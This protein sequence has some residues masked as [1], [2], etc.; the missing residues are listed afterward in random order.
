MYSSDEYE[1]MK[2][3]KNS[4]SGGFYQNNK[5]LV[6]VFIAIILIAIVVV[7]IKKNGDSTSSKTNVNKYS[8]S[9]YP[10]NDITLS[11]GNSTR[12][13]AIV[14]SNASA[15]VTWSSSDDGVVS[16][17]NGL[18]RA[19]KY[20][21]TVITATYTHTDSKSYTSKKEITVADGKKDVT[22]SDISI[23]DG[24]LAMPLS[25]TYNIIT[26]PIPSD[27]YVFAKTLTS[28]NE[29]VVKINDEGMIQ[30]VSEGEA[31]VTININEGVIIRNLKVYVSNTYTNT[32]MILNPTKI[33]LSKEIDKIKIGGSAQISYV[34]EPNEAKNT[35]VNWTSSNESVLKVDK[36]GIIEGINEGMATIKIEALNGISDTL[37]ILV[38]SELSQATDIQ[39]PND[40]YFETGQSDTIIPIIIPENAI[41]KSVTC[42]SNNP[43]IVT[44]NS[45][46]TSCVITAISEGQAV[47][48]VKVNSTDVTKNINVIVSAPFKQSS[49]GGSSCRSCSKTC[50]SGQYCS[51]G[52][53]VS[54]KSGNYCS[55]G[56]KIACPAGK[57]S[58]SNSTMPSD[59]TFCA[60]GYYSTG[61][62]KGCIACPAGY[63][64]SSSGATNKSACSV[65]LDSKC[66]ANQYPD[67]NG[68]CKSCPTD[69][70][71]SDVGVASIYK[72]YRTI[73]A[74]NKLENGVLK[75]CNAGTAAGSRK[76]YYDVKNNSCTACSI[77]TYQDKT[78]QTS[79]KPCSTVKKTGATSCSN[80]A[81]PQKTC[82]S[83]QFLEGTECKPCPQGH[84]CSNNK[85]TACP[86]K[87]FQDLGSQ[88]TCKPCEAGYTTK[89]EGSIRCIYK[90]VA[91]SKGLILKRYESCYVPPG[92]ECDAGN[93]YNTKQKNCDFSKCQVRDCRK[94]S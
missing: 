27:A 15:K 20:G 64:T 88:S 7:L 16:V 77:G 2:T 6:W 12:L 51:C 1:Q 55:G 75:P 25:A 49:G 48:T 47:V 8:I 74:G 57:G 34:V 5:L 93:G 70:P 21:K 36:N 44:V 46:G 39:V 26:N 35:I 61:D 37:D 84:K 10:E 30:A 58:L 63:T 33:S 79:C 18:I 28:S 82:P 38:E 23:K 59:C 56:K 53:C 78:G 54:C 29:N 13:V 14:K 52:N 86:V 69:Y 40:L 24:S 31:N 22:L 94:K 91:C 81:N 87:T 41:D 65:K 3:S 83:G 89:G 71:Y 43:A 62:G 67:A 50:P 90:S 11:P 60:K 76:V 32:E 80:D 17:D 9:I 45:T 4:V 42:T 72:C 85:K 68:K 92:M 66:A 73:P 19:L